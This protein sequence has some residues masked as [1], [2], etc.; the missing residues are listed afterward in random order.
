MF[1]N[2][3]FPTTEVMPFMGQKLLLALAIIGMLLF[4]ARLGGQGM[5]RP[6]NL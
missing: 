5:Q 4:F 2:T 1:V 3:Q 6:K